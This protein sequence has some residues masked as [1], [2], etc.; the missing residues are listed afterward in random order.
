MDV[1]LGLNG[2]I[3]VSKHTKELTM[4]EAEANPDALYTNANEV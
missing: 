4:E 2:M 3:W 1:I